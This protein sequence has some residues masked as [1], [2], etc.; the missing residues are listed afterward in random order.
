MNQVNEIRDIFTQMKKNKI[1][2][3]DLLM[4]KMK[5]TEMQNLK[6][7]MI[8]ERIRMNNLKNSFEAIKKSKNDNKPIKEEPVQKKRSWADDSDDEDDDLQRL[9]KSKEEVKINYRQA[10]TNEPEDEQVEKEEAVVE[11][12]EEVEEAWI[13]TSKPKVED[14]ERVG[15]KIYAETREDQKQHIGQGMKPC[16][17]NLAAARRGI[18]NGCKND[19]C[20]FL[21]YKKDRICHHKL[22]KYTNPKYQKVS[23]HCP[24]P[25]CDKIYFAPCKSGQNCKNISRCTWSHIV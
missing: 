7:A 4:Y 9:T 16:M 25:D 23:Y 13:D 24:E 12:E 21:H 5:Q 19:E 22:E 14:D 15:E 6:L 8:A 1:S 2:I 17:Y 3:E 10:V 18:S 11:E 20:T